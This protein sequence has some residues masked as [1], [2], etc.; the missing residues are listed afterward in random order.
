L[1]VSVPVGVAEDVGETVDEG[2]VDGD[3]VGVA[4]VCWTNSVITV[5][6]GT[7]LP[8]AGTWFH[9]VPTGMF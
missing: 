2:V 6:G 1:V 5:L 9:T 4:A 7:S 3:V 8:A